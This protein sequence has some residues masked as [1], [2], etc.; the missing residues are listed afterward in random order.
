SIYI[1]NSITSALSIDQ[2]RQHSVSDAQIKS[3]RIPWSPPAPNSSS[4]VFQIL[5]QIAG[6]FLQFN[7]SPP[8]PFPL[9]FCHGLLF[10]FPLF[11]SFP[12]IHFPKV[13]DFLVPLDEP[14]SQKAPLISSRRT[15]RVIN[16]LPVPSSV[17]WCLFIFHC[18][19]RPTN[20][21]LLDSLPAPPAPQLHKEDSAGRKREV[22]NKHP[23][24]GTRRIDA[25][26][27]KSALENR[28][29]GIA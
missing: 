19:P 8:T 14:I 21:F 27:A 15:T 4:F 6:T 29:G 3:I 18:N 5:R 22:A 1:H 28:R 24:T 11:L 12:P 10:P 25:F 23:P 20:D 26:F 16:T 7:S 9:C 13:G 2:Q 17:L